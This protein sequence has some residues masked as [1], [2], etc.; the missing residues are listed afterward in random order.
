MVRWEDR[1]KILLRVSTRI[2]RK[3]EMDPVQG[4]LWERDKEGKELWD[5]SIADHGVVR[6]A[7]AARHLHRGWVRA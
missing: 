2:T 1:R 6:V 7:S 3:L 5:L 4:I